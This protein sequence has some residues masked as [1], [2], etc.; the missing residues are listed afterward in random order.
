[1]ACTTCQIVWSAQ[2]SSCIPPTMLRLLCDR[3]PSGQSSGPGIRYQ[4]QY[5]AVAVGSA[6]LALGLVATVCCA[7]LWIASSCSGITWMTKDGLRKPNY[8]GSLTQVWQGS[9]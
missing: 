2:H 9:C 1:M 5:L 6:K 8:W 3:P 7:C 4:K